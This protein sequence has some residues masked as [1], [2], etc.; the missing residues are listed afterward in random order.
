MD[1]LSFK[2]FM[3]EAVE[4]DR[5]KD[6]IEGNNFVLFFRKAGEIY[7]APEES[8]LVFAR[9]KNPDHDLPSGWVKEANFVAVNFDKALKGEKV[10]NIFTHKDLKSIEILDKD[11]ACKA[12]C[13]KADKLPDD[14]KQIKKDLKEP[15]DSD[16][17][18][19][20]AANMDKLGER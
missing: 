2:L 11:E 10:R 1:T 14:K 12:L 3:K 13:A 20:K 6:M 7:G 17:S 19:A 4:K 5:I 18:P 15:K 8:R 16:E 9:M